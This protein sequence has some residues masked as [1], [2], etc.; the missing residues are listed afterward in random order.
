MIWPPD[1]TVRCAKCRPDFRRFDRIVLGTA[2]R[3]I[4]VLPVVLGAPAYLAENPDDEVVLPRDAADL[5]AFLRL[6]VRRYGPDGVLWQQHPEVIPVPIRTWQVWNEPDH[7]LYMPH[8]QN[9][10]ARYVELL[11]A[12][13]QGIR[14]EDTGA[15][16]MLA[17]F[18]GQARGG[19]RDCPCGARSAS[20]SPRRRA[21]CGR[22][23][24]FWL[25]SAG[26]WSSRASTSTRG[27][28]P[29]STG[30]GTTRACA[31]TGAVG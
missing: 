21:R 11:K 30:C 16:V 29:T 6:A 2:R 14:A 19:T 25:V 18:A 27:Y 5:G 17:G 1:L 8:T 13:A 10:P 28:R 12:A 20:P 4:S 24:H 31:S 15:K 7:E 23:S 3:R 9:W 26:A 22:C